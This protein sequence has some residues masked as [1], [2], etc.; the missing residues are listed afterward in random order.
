MSS[1]KIP[2][3]NNLS[4]ELSDLLI[5]LGLVAFL[6]VT[7]VKILN[8][9][10]GMLL[11]ALI[12]AV[13]LYPLHQKISKRVAGNQGRAATILVISGILVIG[14]PTMILGGSTADFITRAHD[15]F[16][17]DARIIAQPSPSVA[18]WP[19]VGGKIHDAWSMAAT[20]LPGF[21]EKIKPQ[22]AEISKTLLG[23][24]A[25]TVGGIFQLLFSLIISG[26]MMAYGQP[27]SDAMKKIIRRL[28][29]PEKGEQ[30][31][32]LS[33]ATIRSVSMGVIGVAF[34]QALLLGVGFVFADIPAAGLLAIVVLVLGIA[35]LPATIL[36]IPVIAYVWWSGDSMISNVFFTVYFVV[37]GL[38]DNVLKP[39][40]LGRGVDA[41]MP[42]ILLGALGGMVTGGMIGLFTGAVLLA[43]GYVIFMDWAI[44]EGKNS[45]DPLPDNVT[46]A[47]QIDK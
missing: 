18:E 45:H 31:H 38:A 6:V 21:I 16:Q 46:E 17:N 8:P 26:I 1:N 23:V 13:T 20:D 29:G 42:I 28:S 11:W 24:A 40:F 36:T 7:S 22:L 44:N 10:M 39:I 33:T 3:S 5:R 34:I 25:G 19:L 27:G 14:I 37:A 47:V 12:L 43:L 15:A 30:L 32:K 9:F 35:Q 41:P 2:I 4:Q